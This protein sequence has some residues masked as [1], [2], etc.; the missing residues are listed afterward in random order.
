M[1]RTLVVTGDCSA[2][3][4]AR[5]REREAE[6]KR[7]EALAGPRAGELIA[8]EAQA[9]QLRTEL[10]AIMAPAL[11]ERRTLDPVEAERYDDA[12]ERLELVKRRI[13]EITG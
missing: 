13:R 1:F 7:A 6:R 5:R 2:E 11:A 10:R 4:E 9:N 8:L 3:L 12:A